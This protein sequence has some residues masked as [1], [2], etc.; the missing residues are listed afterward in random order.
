MR[1]TNQK[2]L[3]LSS[4]Q[5]KITDTKKNKQKLYMNKHEQEI[6]HAQLQNYSNIKI[7]FRN[8]TAVRNIFST[9]PKA[10]KYEN[11]K[12]CDCYTVFQLESQFSF[13][14]IELVHLPLMDYVFWDITPCSP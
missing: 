14:C 10:N 9:T 13:A 7:A 1:P 12:H 11:T 2:N 6:T 5:L 3:T 4:Y 8:T